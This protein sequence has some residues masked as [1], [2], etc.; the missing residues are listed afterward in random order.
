MANSAFQNAF[1]STSRAVNRASR[2]VSWTA[3]A[4]GLIALGL[5][6]WVFFRKTSLFDV[7]E[8][9]GFPSGLV[10]PVRESVNRVMSKFGSIATVLY[11]KDKTKH[12]ASLAR[13][14]AELESTA[15]NTMV[16]GILD[17]F[18]DVYSPKSV[19]RA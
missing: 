6:L 16:P 12:D 10:V 2:T 8:L 19:A 11:N 5:S 13:E 18:L 14:L 7:R 9:S 1:N 4:V 17:S 3:L 15:V